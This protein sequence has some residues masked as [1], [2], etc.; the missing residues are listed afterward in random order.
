[1]LAQVDLYLG[2]HPGSALAVLV[3]EVPTEPLLLDALRIAEDQGSNFYV[4]CCG[5]QLVDVV[6]ALAAKYPAVQHV[7]PP[8]VVLNWL[9]QAEAAHRRCKGVLPKQYTFQL[10]SLKGLASPLKPWLMQLQQEGDH[11]RW[12]SP[13][14]EIVD[15]IDNTHADFLRE[16]RESRAAPF[17][18]DACGAVVGQL[19]KCGSC[20]ETQYCS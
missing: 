5:Y 13:P 17:E 2:R 10:D 12:R 14:P 9:Q 18:C 19:R 1:M 4:A 11:S 3:P 7:N 15:N 6:G 8:S 16:L 20:K